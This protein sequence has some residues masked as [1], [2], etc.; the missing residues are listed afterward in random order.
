MRSVFVVLAAMAATVVAGGPASAQNVRKP[1]TAAQAAALKLNGAQASES[2]GATRVYVVQ[3]AAKPAIAYEGGIA[4]LAKSAPARGERYDSRSSQ[5]QMYA[6][7][8]AAQQD[9]ALARVGASHRKIYSYRHALNGFA[10][11]LT[12]A[13]AARLRKDKTVANVW[14]DRI[15]PVDTNNSPRFLGLLNKRVGLRAFHGLRG[16]N[17]VIGVIDSG[18][19]QEHPSF[20]GTGFM[21]PS[22]WN[23]ICQAGEGW[24]ETD[25]NNKLIGARYFFD[26][27]VAGQPFED[28]IEPTEFK[29]ARDADGHGTHTAS[30]AAGREVLA[31]LSGTPL[32]MISGMA[33]DAYLAIYRACWLA[34]GAPLQGCAFSDT[35]M[36]TDTAVADGV[37]VISY[38]I[39]TAPA[40]TDPQDIAFLFANDANVFIARSAGNAGPGPGT[41]NAGE[42]WVT[43]VAASTLAGTGFTL[44]ARVNSPAA[45]AGDY[46]ALEGAITKPLAESGPITNDVVAANPIDACAPIA[47]IGGKIVLIQ[48]GACSFVQ[49]VEAAVNAGASAVLMYTNIL[50][51]GTENPKVVMGVNPTPLTQMIPGV[52]TDNAP[53]VALRKQLDKG[54][55]VNATLAAGIFI[56]EQLQGNIMAGFSSRGPYS[57]VGDWVKPDVTAPGV[58]ILAGNTPEP[59]SGVSGEFFQYLQGTSMSTPHVAGIGALLREAYPNWTSGQI[60]SAI[61]T[62]ARRGVVKEDG[63]TPADPFDFGSGHLKPNRADNPGLTY[64]QTFFD[65]LA[66]S[67]NTVTPLVVP[68][69]CDLLASLGFFTD[70]ADLNLASIGVD[71]VVGEQTVH[72]TVTNVGTTYATYE[73]LAVSPPGFKVE[74]NPKTLTMNPAES[75]PFEVQIRNVD[76]PPG[77][78]RFGALTWRDGQ[79]HEV[80]SPIAVNAIPFAAPEEITG[81]GADGATSFDIA[82]GYNGAYTAGA[83]GLVEPFVTPFPITDDPLD[84]FDFD[85][86]ATDEVIAFLLELPPGT[87]Y[88]QWSLFDPYVD[89]AHDMDMY[90]FYC[91]DFFCT[92]IDQSFTATSNERV[93]VQFPVNDPAIDDPYLV[94]IHGFNTEGGLPAR[95]IMFDWTVL[96]PE[97]NMTVSGPASAVLGQT[98]TVNVNW[99]GLLTGPGEKQ[100]GA[101]SHSDDTGIQGLTI[102][103]IENDGGAGFDDLCALITCPPPAP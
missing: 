69:D 22:N 98:D 37:H 52:M 43:T 6:A 2:R 41:T 53:G 36:A 24:A 21:P 79:G 23:G 7:H 49:K 67:C 63:V 75:K 66:A 85:T 56:T 8:I 35:A 54:Q 46:P 102:V 59:N 55:T 47:P 4:G 87:T 64:D 89:G 33:P 19:I 77:A 1:A 72:R 83:H 57:T 88:A 12:A 18:A 13:Q 93:S 82:F 86:A 15:M 48:R 101:V 78:W 60:K 70:S 50:P 80:R 76:A 103:N 16:K 20:D 71:G 17:V 92:Q 44:A 81:A 65:F 51:D 100:A 31:S 27:F 95:G 11:R 40:F 96:G 84:S 73:A 34:I 97:T 29:S 94:F 61:M 39:S 14:Q 74:V 32:A 30:T 58:Q 3:M 38:S 5:V 62:T 99:I 9:A 26:G 25:C 10:A 28:V 90:L 45:V 91:P 42:P 68:D